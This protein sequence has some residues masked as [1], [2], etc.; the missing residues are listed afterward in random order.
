[1][2]LINI[3]KLSYQQCIEFIAKSYFQEKDKAA[4]IT[5]IICF[6]NQNPRS[7]STV[8]EE[9]RWKWEIGPIKRIMLDGYTLSTGEKVNDITIVTRLGYGLGAVEVVRYDEEKIS[10]FLK[11]FLIAQRI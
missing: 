9:C 6:F 2:K 7:M 4:K 5:E 11:P 8:E 3:K 1:M 10:E